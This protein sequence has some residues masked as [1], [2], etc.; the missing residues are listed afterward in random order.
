M[1][2][3]NDDGSKSGVSMDIILVTKYQ[4]DTANGLKKPKRVISD[5]A[6]T[7]IN[8]NKLKNDTYRLLDDHAMDTGITENI[9]I[10][11]LDDETKQGY[12]VAKYLLQLV[13]E[14]EQKT[15]ILRQ[16]WYWMTIV[17]KVCLVSNHI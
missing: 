3:E 15:T 4:Y 12:R 11:K 8:N 17:I 13:N 6:L 9:L 5:S 14:Y 7:Y 16:D 10:S 2:F 1:S